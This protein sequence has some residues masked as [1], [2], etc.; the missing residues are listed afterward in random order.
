MVV[1]AK[2]NAEHIARTHVILFAHGPAR[3]PAV[4]E[5]GLWIIVRVG[6]DDAKEH[7]L[8]ALLVDHRAHEACAKG[9]RV[10]F[11]AVVIVKR[12]MFGPDAER[13]PVSSLIEKFL[14][15]VDLG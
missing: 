1:L 12:R 9:Q 8:V 11:G 2:R 13:N 15:A 3:H 4:A 7:A 14:E 10:F 5:G 6:K